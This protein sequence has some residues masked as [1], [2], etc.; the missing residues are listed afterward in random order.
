MTTVT[1]SAASQ[2]PL[3]MGGHHHHHQYSLIKPSSHPRMASAVDMCHCAPGEAAGGGG[4]VGANR[5][6]VLRQKAAT[7]L[8]QPT[9]VQVHIFLQRTC[10]LS[11]GVEGQTEP[12]FSGH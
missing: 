6:N 3:S 7:R 10:S 1:A 4:Q 12:Q 9:S 8:Q 11:Q 2:R 5:G